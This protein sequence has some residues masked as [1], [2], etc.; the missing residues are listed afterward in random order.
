[1]PEEKT[2]L[3]KTLSGRMLLFAVVPTAIILT[4][5]ILLVAVT[6]FASVRRESEAKLHTLAERVA[7]E[8]ELGNANA[9][10][11]A[12]SMAMIQEHGMFGMR[13]VS[14]NFLRRLLSEF[15][16]FTG[17]SFGYEPN[18]DRNDAAFRQSAE[19]AEI[20]AAL[21][22]NGRF[23]PYWFRDPEANDELRLE[24][25]LHMEESL[26]Y[27]GCK[28]MFLESGRASVMIT[29]PYEYEGKAIVEH[30][31][32]IVIDGEF[33][34]IAGVDRALSDVAEF[35]NTIQWRDKVDIY[36]ISRGGRF[37]A[38]TTKRDFRT[39]PVA[40]TPYAEL[41][42]PFQESRSARAL[43]LA[44]DPIDGDRYYYVSAPIPTGE[45][46]V[47]LR[48]SESKII[49]PIR[50]QVVSIITLVIAA[51]LV[52]ALVSWRVTRSTASR[53]RRAVFAADRL[54][55]GDLH[56]DITLE[57]DANDEVGLFA[58]S[59]NRLVATY[60]RITDVCVAIANGDFSKRLESRSEHDELARAINHMSTMR[61]TAERELRA[62]S[63]ELR[64]LIDGSPVPMVITTVEGDEQRIEYINRT[65]SEFFGYTLEDMLDFEQWARVALPDSTNRARFLERYRE[66]CEQGCPEGR[67][68]PV[69]GT[70][71]C[72]N[73]EE[74]HVIFSETAVGG[75][76]FGVF[77]DLTDRK[78]AEEA[79]DEARHVAEAANQ[80]KSDFLANVSHEIRTPMNAIIGMAHL[81]QRTEMSP[82][83]KD[84]LT[85]IERSAHSL[86]GIINDILDFSKIEAGHLE[87]EEAPF[88]LDEVLQNLSDTIALR[89]GEKALEV[90]F[91]TAPDVPLRLVGDSLR[92]QQV[93]INLCTNAIKF[94]DDGE[95]V[96]SVETVEVRE[97]RA[98][99]RFS[100][101]DTGIG[102]TEEQRQRLFRPFTQADSSTT[103]KYGGTG[104]G[105]SISKQL[106]EMM[107]GDFEVD[108]EPG[109]G[110]L[111]RFTAC[112]G[113][114]KEAETRR[115]SAPF[116]VKGK[117]VLVVD[118]NASSRQIFQEMLE[119][120]SFRVALVASGAE[121]ITELQQAA[122][123]ESFD[124]VIMD[125]RMPE[126]DG[127]EA[128][129]HI[130]EDPRIPRKPKIIL[131]TA[132][133]NEQVMQQA[134]EEGL[135]GFLMKPVSPSLMLDSISAAFAEG[136]GAAPTPEKRRRA[137]PSEQLRGA[138]ILLAEDNE[139]NQQVAEELLRGAGMEVVI[140]N[141]G[142]EAIDWLEKERFDA[143]LMDIQMPVLDGLAA[144]R[145][146]RAMGKAD[147]RI[148]ALTAHA[149]HDEKQRCLSAGMD[150][151]LSKPFRPHELF[152]II[153]GWGS[154]S[155]IEEP[156]ETPSRP[157]DI[158]AFR[159]QLREAG[160]ED[161]LGAL[162]DAF[163]GDAPA[164]LEAV[165]RAC[166][167]GDTA[168]IASSAH[169]FRAAAGAVSAKPLAELLRRTE[170]SGREGNVTEA[171]SIAPSIRPAT[172]AVLD[173][174]AELRAEVGV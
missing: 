160:I 151:Y 138:R 17:A 119:S 35:L 116:D 55:A 141:N 122:G 16:Q 31:Y 10:L 83:Q 45:W 53:V 50:T 167:E 162:L 79:A 13:A 22:A 120:L 82:R 78:R 111:F 148:V 27:A 41:F 80:A 40:E 18:A 112:F 77:S 1:M 140:A 132:Y 173:L 168:A 153:E 93:L 28:K 100:V 90:L 73:G 21:D 63:Q 163:A 121:A 114:Q 71:R 26:Y 29:E 169:A 61:E 72:K 174:I 7:A 86:L 104:L 135:Q 37:V 91:R 43:T 92:L 171:R 170:L 165:E 19:A 96:V 155:D 88:D 69:E 97:G 2:K 94:T 133:G 137:V 108:S 6:M 42:A 106:V 89:A 4:A 66:Q 136:E 59:F 164:R 60:R 51:L 48:E 9:V 129:R 52:V 11:A 49:G 103:R 34:G 128:S 159:A 123:N 131:V 20:E 38:T 150:G 14:S 56:A 62:R 44:D 134:Q 109:K 101:R 30:T 74:R 12:K 105:L 75:R 46:H 158:A 156:S 166:L 118:D 117:R 65:F 67:F 47:I 125:W 8:I 57:E 102:M 39:K 127:L 157:I 32:P 172:D 64:E 143:V 95:V 139:I 124:C 5:I 110:S 146:I 24:P 130:L 98:R 70:M 145:E 99:L 54:A 149:L 152:A 107:G 81:F 87:M 113:L 126:M 84:Y 161:A 58:R 147:L 68:E 76:L 36:V 154:A 33:K 3:S 25:L 23:L 144:T 85:K 142:R 15:P 115:L